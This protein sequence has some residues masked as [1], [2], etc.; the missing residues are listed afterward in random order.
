MYRPIAC[1]RKMIK[2]IFIGFIFVFIACGEV[3]KREQKISISI[4][5]PLISE[6]S[7]DD[8]KINIAVDRIINLL[9]SKNAPID[10]LYLKSYQTDSIPW[11]FHIQHYITYVHD[12][13]WELEE[14]RIDSLLKID[15]V[16]WVEYRMIPATGN[17]SG[18]DRWIEYF[19]ETDKLNDYLLQ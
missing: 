6:V 11:T 5:K 15:S 10:S 9:R 16:E 7:T 3:K 17:I 12:N 8:P 1:I 19:P 18:Y 2:L 13:Q 14:A 4:K